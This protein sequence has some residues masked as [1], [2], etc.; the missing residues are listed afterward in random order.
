MQYLGI[1]S[2]TELRSSFSNTRLLLESFRQ[3]LAIESDFDVNIKN[4]EYQELRQKYVELAAKYESD[5]L[6]TKKLANKV[7]DGLNIKLGVN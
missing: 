7:Q 5:M 3:Q 6:L 2:N 4:I 1:S